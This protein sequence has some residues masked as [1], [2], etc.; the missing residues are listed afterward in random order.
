MIASQK[1]VTVQKDERRKRR[2]ETYIEAK[3][4]MEGEKREKK[5]KG[6][7]RREMKRREEKKGKE[8]REEKA[9]GIREFKRKEKGRGE[10]KK[11]VK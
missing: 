8:K 3:Q 6:E 10:G 9:R 2:G 11:R 1:F 5:G 7:L 4:E